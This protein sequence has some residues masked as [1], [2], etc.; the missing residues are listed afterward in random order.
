[1][2]DVP[3]LVPRTSPQAEITIA[4]AQI[5]LSHDGS[6]VPKA[7]QEAAAK[8]ARLVAFPARSLR[9]DS[10]ASLAPVRSAAKEAGVYVAVGAGGAAYVFSP[11]GEQLTRYVPGTAPA[12]MWFELDGI[13]SIVSMGERD[14]LWTEIPELAAV[15]GVQIR[16]HLAH[17]TAASERDDLERRQL[18]AA[19]AS[20][21]MLTAVVNAAGPSAAGHSAIWDDL[22]G[23][24]QPGMTWIASPVSADL[25]VEAERDETILYVTRK[26]NK[27]N[28]HLSRI[29]PAKKEWWE[30]GA[31]L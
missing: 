20:Y 13:P 30:R 24:Q 15:A 22:G 8:G 17:D 2:R 27:T 21:G 11:T 25:V 9:S 31:R 1:M 23:V 26:V 29:A 3:A 18:G 16:V 28:P 6:V 4:T 19:M 10:P 12:S 14:G 5:V 7:I